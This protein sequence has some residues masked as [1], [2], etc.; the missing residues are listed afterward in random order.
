MA[1]DNIH[2]KIDPDEFYR[3]WYKGLSK[4]EKA[5]ADTYYPPPS[6]KEGRKRLE[7]EANIKISKARQAIIF[8]KQFFGEL[9]LKLQDRCV[10]PENWDMYHMNNSL[11]IPAK[12]ICVSDSNYIWNPVFINSIDIKELC[13]YIVDLVMKPAL[14]HVQRAGGRDPQRWNGASNCVTSDITMDALKVVPEAIKDNFIEEH[15][16]KNCEVVYEF[17]P[18]QP[19]AS[20]GVG[21]NITGHG[22]GGMAPAL[23]PEQSAE[24]SE[25]TWLSHLC[26]AIASATRSRG[27]VPIGA[28]LMVEELLKPKVNW[29]RY[30]ANFISANSSNKSDYSF[31][32]PNR[33]FLH[34]KMILPSLYKECISEGVIII[35][36]SGS[37][38]AYQQQF[39]S[40]AAAVLNAG[41]GVEMVR[42]ISC[43]A[44]AVHEEDW[45]VQGRR[46]RPIP[47]T[48]GGGTSFVP[49][50]ELI[51]EKNW[52]P[53]FVIYL[54]DMYGDFPGRELDPGCP[55]LWMSTTPLDQINVDA[56]KLGNVCYIELDDQKH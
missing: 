22:H 16:G 41:D 13:A 14:L 40:E 43:D 53:E 48:G 5:F 10:W 20:A 2:K 33:M 4:E 37:C 36:T 42:I 35:D 24:R 21:F 38:G 1:E 32:R 19:P 7:R 28:K 47:L 26:S 29:K 45:E 8:N 12:T 18:P 44:D 3:E 30:L 49:P 34:K 9:V 51:R 23:N 54:T 55:V 52:R 39:L 27:Y 31:Q 46:P 15:K 25:A 17:I 11:T 50:F 56:V 6:D